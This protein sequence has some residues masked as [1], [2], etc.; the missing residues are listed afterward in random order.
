[1]RKSEFLN[2]IPITDSEGNQQG[3]SKIAGKQAVLTTILSRCAIVGPILIFPPIIYNSV[4]KLHFMKNKS[5]H[6]PIQL[7]IIAFWYLY[8]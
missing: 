1:M 4:S 6:I 7:L 5:F 2:G 8:Y 3:I